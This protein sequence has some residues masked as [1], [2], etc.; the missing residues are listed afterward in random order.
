M[1]E[2]VTAPFT[3]AQVKSLN[4]YQQSG[5]IHPFTCG[6]GRR[7]D[8]AHFDGEGVL[9]ATADGWVCLFCDYTQDWAHAWMADWRWRQI[10]TGG[11]HGEAV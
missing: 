2:K 6:S 1:E 11:S 8:A 7:K 3:L 5:Y 10:Q 9:L 4:A